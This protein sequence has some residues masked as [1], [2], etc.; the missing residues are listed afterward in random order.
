MCSPNAAYRPGAVRAAVTAVQHHHLEIGICTTAAAGICAVFPVPPLLWAPVYLFSLPLSL[1]AIFEANRHPRH[2]CGHCVQM[3]IEAI[4][5]GA[6]KW[7]AWMRLHHR[8]MSHPFIYI[9]TVLTMLPLGLFAPEPL[10]EIGNIVPWL[11]TMALIISCSAH[12]RFA[13]WCTQCN[14][15][16]G[17]GGD[18]DLPEITPDPIGRVVSR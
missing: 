11:I 13:L 10:S 4:V 8:I 3:L 5:T 15:G 1:W 17:G 9:G 6:I 18:D 14:G 2:Y 16:G 12:G 7:Q